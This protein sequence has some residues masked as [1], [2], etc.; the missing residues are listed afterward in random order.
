MPAPPSNDVDALTSKLLELR[1]LRASTVKEVIKLEASGDKGEAPKGVD[2]KEERV[3]G[4][5]NGT[6]RLFA[7]PKSKE[8]PDLFELREQQLPA[9]DAATAMIEQKLVIAH[10]EAVRKRVDENSG[11]W[12]DLQRQRAFM[13]AGLRKLNGTIEAMRA[14]C[15]S[16]G[17]APDD[18]PFNGY[19]GLL[20]GTPDAQFTTGHWAKEYLAA[21]V[22]AKIITEKELANV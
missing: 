14:S 20:L 7:K 19:S 22:R 16:G 4:L 5:L 6:G 12:R 13:V 3:R 17:V 8:G 21:C 18:L 15:S 2:D 10:A 9:I 11:A 1:Q